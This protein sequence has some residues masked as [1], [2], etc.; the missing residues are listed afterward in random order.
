V[1]GVVAGVNRARAALGLAAS[2]AL[3]AASG[4]TATAASAAAPAGTGDTP[5]CTDTW[6]G[7][8]LQGQW[9]DATNWSTGQVPGPASDV[10]ITVDSEMKILTDV[11][12]KVQSLRIGGFDSFDVNGTASHHLTVAVATSITI[13]PTTNNVRSINLTDATISTP[14]INDQ[15]GIITTTGNCH[16]TSPDIIFSEAIGTQGSLFASNGTTTLSSLS[17][18]NNGTLTGIGIFA[19][20]GATVVLPGDITRMVS[21]FVNIDANSAIADPAG[22]NALTGL[23]SV[24]GGS[25]TDASGLKLTASSFTDAGDVDL[26]GGTTTIDGPITA[27]GGL[28]LSGDAALKAS[29]V[30]MSNKAELVSEGTVVITGNLVNDGSVVLNTA[31]STLKV[32]GDYTQAAA[33]SLATEIGGL[34]TVTGTAALAGELSSGEVFPK[35]GDNATTLRYGSLSGGFTSTVL[36]IKTTVKPHEID[37]VIV[38]Q[39]EAETMSVAPG[40][41][42]LVKGR[43]FVFGERVKLFLDHTGGTPVSAANHPARTDG[44]VPPFVVPI[45][46]SATAG[47]HKLIAVGS[48]GSR[49][50]TTITVS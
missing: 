20:N 48:D 7:Q 31:T 25:L 29:Q 8:A 32:T 14:R 50:T 10:C 46:A 23:T 45:P 15:G 33:A 44:I 47:V 19:S 34:L 49:A 18:L 35:P 27:T 17:Q 2:A 41:T 9:T 22:H 42:V 3:V 13:V 11:S 36:G 4:G 6:V 37:V 43:S 16:L 30:T 40:Q 21:A 24:N 1:S 38:P 12:V 39:I 5:A 26:T 28:E